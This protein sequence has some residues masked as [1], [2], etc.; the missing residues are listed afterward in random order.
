MRGQNTLVGWSSDLES[1]GRRFNSRL[2]EGHFGVAFSLT[3]GFLGMCPGVVWGSLEV[4][5]GFG[6]VLEKMLDGVEKLKKSKMTG[7]MF[8]GSGH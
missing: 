5:D 4:S 3:L 1:G 7:S 2:P 6:M 8:P